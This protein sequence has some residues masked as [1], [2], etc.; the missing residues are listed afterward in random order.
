MR[1]LED[2]IIQGALSCPLCHNNMTVQG[3]SLVCCGERKHCFDFAS[4]GYVNLCSPRQS[5]GGD[6]KQAVRARTEFLNKQ[7]YRPIA[8]ALVEL[9]CKFAPVGLPVLD[10]GCG[11]GYYTCAIANE[12]YSVIGVDLSK[13]ATDA[14]AKRAARDGF[15]NAF[16]ATGSVFELPV[17]DSSVGAITSIFAPCAADHFAAKLARGG[18]LIVAAAG[19]GHLL[20]LKKV[21]YDD[22]HTNT[23]RADMPS[24]MIKIAEKRVRYSIDVI[25]NADVKSL[26][27][28]TPYYWR[29]SPQDAQKLESVDAL[30]TEVDVVLSVYTHNSKTEI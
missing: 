20:G 4:G 5:G 30:T 28:M 18:C 9:V 3:T 21:I 12:G 22:V 16:F 6:S 8:D 23:E 7:Y 2:K 17:K 29:T 26:F 11:E 10:A 13:F 15:D 25:G 27:A 1:I 19:E 14:A 24:D